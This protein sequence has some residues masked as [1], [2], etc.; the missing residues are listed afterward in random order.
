MIHTAAGYARWVRNCWRM[1]PLSWRG[2][3]RSAVMIVLFHGLFRDDVEVAN[4]LCDPQQG[5]TA[6][7]FRDFV[8]SLLDNGATIR[9]LGAAFQDPRPGLTT[10]ITFDDGYFNNHQALAVLDQFEVPATFFISTNHVREQ[11]AFWWDVLYREGCRRGM[12]G[13][14]L[15]RQAQQLKR[16]TADEIDRQL[17]TSFGARA[18]APVSDC[19]RPFT[20]AELADFATSRFVFLGNHTSDHG[21]LVNYDMEGM[22]HQIIEAQRFLSTITSKGAKS[23]AY[24]NGNVDE[25]VRKVAAAVGLEFG[26]TTRAGL[27]LTAAPALME[28]RRL[29]VWGVPGASRQAKMLASIIPIGADS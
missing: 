20:S 22:R 2:R 6:S 26:L 16:L 15:R 7:Y 23:I 25:R 9:E 28:L 8:E 19:D 11:K 27:N 14:Q 5:I 17:M 21:I 4:G 3:E 10:V 1:S 13:S 24:P 12:T 29:I 18:F